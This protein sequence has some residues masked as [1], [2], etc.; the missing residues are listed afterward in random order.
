MSRLLHKES[1]Y[2]LLLDTFMDERLYPCTCREQT[3]GLYTISIGR[4]EGSERYLAW[5]HA[6]EW[7]GH[8]NCFEKWKGHQKEK[9]KKRKRRGVSAGQTRCTFPFRTHHQ[10]FSVGNSWIIAERGKEKI[11]GDSR[12][13]LEKEGQIFGVGTAGL[14]INY[15]GIRKYY[16]NS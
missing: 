15:H 3:G 10:I 16:A 12:S 1:R 6:G 5:G 11:V 14:I 13:L 9:K 8:E 7:V 4:Y 2:V